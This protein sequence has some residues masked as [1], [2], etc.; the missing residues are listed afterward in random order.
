MADFEAERELMREAAEAWLP[1]DGV[2]AVQV[3]ITAED[4]RE[5]RFNALPKQL[6]INWEPL[7]FELGLQS[8]GR[9]IET[10]SHKLTAVS[11]G[12]RKGSILA[13]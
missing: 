4:G 5:F 12:H 9:L 3:T 2:K 11:F 7:G 8:T 1:K 6:N 10:V 13:E